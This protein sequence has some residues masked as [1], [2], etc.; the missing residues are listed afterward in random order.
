MHDDDLRNGNAHCTPTHV[1]DQLTGT[2]QEKIIVIYYQPRNWIEPVEKTFLVPSGDSELS[3]R[4]H[5]R[6]YLF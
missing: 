6:D 3:S 2:W 4:L 5:Q 1:Y